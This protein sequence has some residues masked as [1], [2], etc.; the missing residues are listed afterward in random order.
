MSVGERQK[1][2]LTTRYLATMFILMVAFCSSIWAQSD[3]LEQDVTIKMTNAKR[4][5]IFRS[6]TRQTAYTFTYDTDLIRPQ[7]FVT[8]DMEDQKLESVLDLMFPNKF[9][10]NKG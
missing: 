5:T 2:I 8:L 6:L 1:Q 10:D 9:F 7:E 4:Q 3:I